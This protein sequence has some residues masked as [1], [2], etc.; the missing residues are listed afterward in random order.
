[1]SPASARVAVIGDSGSANLAD[2]VVADLANEPSINLLERQDM[3]K[4]GDEL[5]LQQLAGDNAA[6][7]GRMLNADGLLFIRKQ[8]AGFQVRL[9]AVGL[10]YAVFDDTLAAQ[11]DPDLP[12]LAKEIARRIV[13]FAP[14]LQL[15]PD[16]AVPISVLNIRAD[17]VSEDAVSLEKKLS[18][19]LESKLAAQPNYVVLERRHAGAI[20]FEKSLAPLNEPAPLEGAYVVD[21]SFNQSMQGGNDLTVHLRLRSPTSQENPLEIQGS[22]NDLGPLTDR[23]VAAIQKAIGKPVTSTAW[24]PA[25]EARE[26]LLEGIWAWQHGAI[27]EA[28]EALDSASLLGETA[29]DLEAA[30][31]HVLCAKAVGTTSIT[32]G[33]PDTPNDPHPEARIEAILRAF[34][35]EQS[36]ELNGARQPLQILSNQDLGGMMTFYRDT[37]GKAA[38]SLLVMLDRTQNAQADALRTKLDAYVDF[39]PLHGQVP[40]DVTTTIL[41]LDDMAR[42]P[43]EEMA[44]VHK[45]IDSRN[46][47]WWMSWHGQ[48]NPD[49]FCARFVS[50]VNQRHAMY[51]QFLQQLETDDTARP[52]AFIDRAIWSDQL[53]LNPDNAVQQCVDELWNER[54]QLLADGRLSLFLSEVF[55]FEDPQTAPSAN[56]RLLDLMHFLLQNSPRIDGHMPQA[57]QP[58]HFPAAEA[59]KFWNDF[60]ALAAKSPGPGSEYFITDM[61]TRYVNRWGLPQTNAASAAVAMANAM[62]LLPPP[63]PNTLPKTAPQVIDALVVSHFWY[64]KDASDAGPY[65]LGHVPL[66]PDAKGA[67]VSV[68]EGGD[69]QPLKAAL[70]HVDIDPA[71][72]DPFTTAPTLEPPVDADAMVIAP[73]A[74]YVLGSPIYQ[75]DQSQVARY[76]L[77]SLQWSQHDVPYSQGLFLAADHLYLTLSGYGLANRQSGIVLYDA[78]TGNTTLLA[79]SRRRPP[80]NQFDNRDS[81]GAPNI[82]T[83][84]GN[85]PCAEIGI[86]ETYFIN[87]SPGNWQRMIDSGGAFYAE[88]DGTR[89]LIY[90][91]RDVEDRTPGDVVFMVDPAKNQPEL[92]LGAP[93]PSPGT[94][95]QAAST[96][97][98]PAPWPTPPVWPASAA[99]SRSFSE[100]GFRGDDIYA[101]FSDN[102]LLKNGLF[103][104][105]RG[106]AE[107]LYIP[108]EFR[109]GD[110]AA[111]V[112]KKIQDAQPAEKLQFMENPLMGGLMKMGQTGIFFIDH[113][114]GFYFLPY[115]DIDAY[116]KAN[117][118][119]APSAMPPPPAPP[120]PVGFP[121]PYFVPHNVPHN[122]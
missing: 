80:Q 66:V 37:V 112:F 59:S 87:E 103:W 122:N 83:G 93:A 70:Y 8:P 67:W 86:G 55:G 84:P 98:P 62:R 3:M 18:L 22:S 72:A 19:L 57:W 45:M 68:L 12:H 48:T 69:D 78:K 51:L 39:D 92:L 104:Y 11:A 81:Y 25:K 63:P 23:M 34:D 88:G 26:Y 33:F 49:N 79:S 115:A 24:Q 54:Q 117:P 108:L 21:G 77:T 10:A 121:M 2:L 56:S 99:S 4:V 114:Y 107:P 109:P 5:H 41:D 100:Y 46:A 27:D 85:R 119:G 82:F 113:D 105:R 71:Q 60:Q 47:F 38:A 9:T 13:D 16:A 106:Q 52:T 28:L 89:T 29:P 111:A 97:P 91:Q 73:D 61:R 30:R 36:F 43:D 6:S 15:K 75:W 118:A 7:L 35:E 76:D 42:S 110:D 1:M 96:A 65:E 20:L 120:R 17:V 74:L 101:R 95:R 50:D 58:E 64:P 44:Y 94:T 102:R 90:G 116:L 32:N 53:K 40:K 14:K 31:I